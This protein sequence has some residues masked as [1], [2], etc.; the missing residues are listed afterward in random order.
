MITT[1]E[2]SHII[3]SPPTLTSHFYQYTFVFLMCK[4]RKQTAA[5]ESRR[6]GTIGVRRWKQKGWGQATRCI[7]CSEFPSVLWRC[8]LM[9]RRT[10]GPQTTCATNPLRFSSGTRGVRKVRKTRWLRFIWKTTGP[11]LANNVKTP[12]TEIRKMAATDICK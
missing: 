11:A 10:S 4:G 7:H 6:T 8:W 12:K 9:T 1:Q 2:S 5:H 3:H